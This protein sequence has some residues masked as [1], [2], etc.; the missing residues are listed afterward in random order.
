MKIVMLEGSPNKNGSSNLLAEC[1]QQGAKEAG[2]LWR[3]LTQP[4]LRYTLVLGAFTVA[5][6]DLVCRRMM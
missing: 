6:R 3:L 2:M 4:T 1:F 5:M